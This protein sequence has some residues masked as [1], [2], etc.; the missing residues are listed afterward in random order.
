MSKEIY[1]FEITKVL[2]QKGIRKIEKQK[3]TIAITLSDTNKVIRSTIHKTE[4]DKSMKSLKKACSPHIDDKLVI[5]EIV[6]IISLKWNELIDDDDDSE[7]SPRNISA[8]TINNEIEKD[9]A[10]IG[11]ISPETWKTTLNEKY[12]NLMKVID[13]NLPQL[14]LQI[15]LELSVKS[16]LNIKDCTLPLAVIV[17]GAPSSLKTQGI[18]LLRKWPCTYYTDNFSARSFVSHNTSVNKEELKDIDLLP[19]IVNKIFLTPELAPTFASNDD[20]L[21]QILG[22]IT[23]VLD[24]QGYFSNS[25]AHGGRGYKGQM[26]FVWIGAAVDIPRR[27]H[28]YLSTLGPKLYFL[29]LPK[30]VYANPEEEYL[31]QIK[32]PDFGQKVNAIQIALFDYLKWF[33]L[34]PLAER[35]QTSSLLKIVWNPDADDE[36]SIKYIIKLGMLLAHLRGSVPTWDTSHFQGSEY[37]YG[38][39]TIEEPSRAIT[40]LTNLARGHALS[41]GRNFITKEDISI[42]IKVVLSTASIERV[43]VFDLLLA[44]GGKLQTPVIKDSLNVSSPTAHRT[45]AEFKAIG[46]VDSDNAGSS[47][48]DEITLKPKFDWFLTAEFQELRDD[49]KPEKYTKTETN[50]TSDEPR[51]A[52]N[53]NCEINAKDR[54]DENGSPETSTDIEINNNHISDL[55]PLPATP[56]PVFDIPSGDTATTYSGREIVRYYKGSDLWRCTNDKCKLKGDIYYMRNHEC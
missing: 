8:N 37:A 40:Q 13:E 20:D 47:H 54:Q 39:A 31:K 18:E 44:R 4:F 14:R 29:R 6:M 41:Q 43:A 35:D 36:E 28:K 52:N 46:L 15:E 12:S 11:D 33:E 3:E 21:V 22:I 38:M 53:A 7:C 51:G 30:E 23:R 48:V 49:Y 5:E 26:M 1:D 10:A 25:G 24:G 2:R 17:L 9:K 16:I 50:N 19:R 56:T 27:V 55:T 42:V 34:Y 45:M 32:G